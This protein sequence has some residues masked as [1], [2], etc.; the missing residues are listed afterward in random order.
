MEEG[1]GNTPEKPK[2]TEW[3]GNLVNMLWEHPLLD[4]LTRKHRANFRLEA[5][6][7]IRHFGDEPDNYVLVPEG[8]LV[9][10]V[11]EDSDFDFEMFRSE[12]GKITGDNLW[13]IEEFNP[14]LR[15]NNTIWKISDIFESGPREWEIFSSLLITPDRYLVG[16]VELAR[17]TRMELVGKL[18]RANQTE[19]EVFEGWFGQ[20]LDKMINW[21]KLDETGFVESGGK[22]KARIAKRFGELGLDEASLERHLSRLKE[23]VG[24]EESLVERLIASLKDTEGRVE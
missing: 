9:W 14:G 15:I 21:P 10:L 4:G 1:A 24:G 7:M 2:D 12:S 3:L 13:D 22:R 23:M 19:R 17:Q 18:E 5:E 11:G 16:N 8:S 20:H 6:K